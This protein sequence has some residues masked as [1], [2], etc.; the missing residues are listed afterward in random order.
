[1]KVVYLHQYFTPPDGCGAT[2]SYEMARRLVTA[3]FQVTMIT[4]DCNIPSHYFE[5][6]SGRRFT[7]EGIE[8]RVIHVPYSNRMP[9]PQRL[10]AFTKFTIGAAIVVARSDRADI[11]LAT[12]TPLTICLPGVLAK[13]VHRAPMVFE[14][15]DLWPGIPIAIGA[16][17][18]PLTIIAARWLERFAYRNSARIIA[19]S[20]GMAEGV[21]RTGYPRDRVM[22]IPN[23]CD[24]ELFSVPDEDGKHFLEDHPHLQTG[25]LILYAGTL[26]MVNGIEYLVDMAHA[27]ARIDPSVRFL[28]VGDGLEAG[29][30]RRRAEELKVLGRNFFMMPSVSKAELPR[31]LSAA[32][33]STSL[34]VPIP[35]LRHNSAN[36]FFDSLAAG[37][38]VMINYEGWQADLLKET[39]AGIVVPPAD[40]KVAA[41]LL[42]AFLTDEE[43]LDKAGRAAAQLADTTFNRDHLTQKLIATFEQVAYAP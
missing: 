14:V 25:P 9:Y 13:I 11:V 22:V 29:K 18:H 27:M 35:E 24:V 12:S 7:L 17:R 23:G 38:P 8:V 43:Q 40:P 3:G 39:G 21:V 5:T 30:V 33:I 2:R 32:S 28:V 26:G 16:L 36:K 42:H 37:K 31:L 19:L 4:S 34:V 20:P 10:W 1:M 6:G 41:E 15:R